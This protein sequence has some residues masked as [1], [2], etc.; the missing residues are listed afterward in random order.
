M[1]N[2]TE[3]ERLKNRSALG[4]KEMYNLDFRVSKKIE[5]YLFDVEEVNYALFALPENSAARAVRNVNLNALF[6]L[7]EN[8]LRLL[9]VS[10]V[11]LDMNDKPRIMRFSSVKYTKDDKTEF[12]AS[13][14]PATSADVFRHHL[15]E[16]HIK[17]LQSFVDLNRIWL[18]GETDTP[19]KPL[20]EKFG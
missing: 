1:L 20:S 15:I 11:G 12:N 16:M 19:L 18:P 6:M 4:K 3:K 5:N 7:I 2:P 14:E 13:L 8:I 17:E 10:P 9:R